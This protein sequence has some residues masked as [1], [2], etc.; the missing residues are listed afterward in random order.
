MLTVRRE[1]VN[2]PTTSLYI[3]HFT[4]I[5]PGGLPDPGVLA[6]TFPKIAGWQ[7]CVLLIIVMVGPAPAAGSWEG[8]TPGYSARLRRSR[9]VT[10]PHTLQSIYSSLARPISAAARA[11]LKLSQFPDRFCWKDNLWS[12]RLTAWHYSARSH[13]LRRLRILQARHLPSAVRLSPVRSSQVIYVIYDI[14][15]P[16]L[17]YVGQT[18]NTAFHRLQQHICHGRAIF[19]GDTTDRDLL[20]RTMAQRGWHNFRIF[21][22]EHVPGVFTK[23]KK[24]ITEFRQTALPRELFWK[25]YSARLCP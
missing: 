3:R 12:A 13:A 8:K 2:V 6:G 19:N 10:V 5:L 18:I 14:S 1:S 22:I 20:H 16:R 25:R 24:G 9:P 17:V 23:D 11:S 7:V 4:Q 21:P 15:D